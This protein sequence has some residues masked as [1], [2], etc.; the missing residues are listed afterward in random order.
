M[1]AAFYI[2]GVIFSM[3]HSWKLAILRAL[4]RF[5]HG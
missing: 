3:S 4:P 5:A 1:L 2:F